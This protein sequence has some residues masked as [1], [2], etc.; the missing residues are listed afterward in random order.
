MFCQT[1]KYLIFSSSYFFN[2]K[3][4]Q[5]L[6]QRFPVFCEDSTRVREDKKTVREI[7]FVISIELIQIIH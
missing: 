5:I 1:A 6:F 3:E 2:A 7:V 4:L